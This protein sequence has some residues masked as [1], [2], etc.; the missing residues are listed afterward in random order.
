[1]EKHHSPHQGTHMEGHR[2]PDNSW[3]RWMGVIQIA[4]LLILV[5]QFGTLSGKLS[6]GTAGTGS[7]GGSG[8]QAAPPPQAPSAAQ[9]SAQLNPG[10][11]P[12]DPVLGDAG[13]AVSIVEFSDFQCPF[14]KRAFDQSL[15]DFKNSDYFKSGEV[16]LIYKHF[17]LDSIHPQATPAAV[18]AECAKAQGEFWAFHDTI[19]QNQGAMS[20]GS[21]KQWASDLGLDTGSFSACFDSSDTLAKVRADLSAAQAAGG[22]G[23]PY[24][25]VI[26]NKNGKTQP[27]SGAVPFSKLEEA[28]QAVR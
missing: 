10:I 4:L 13:A 21:Y 20:E 6:T 27:V 8:T 12:E 24:F 16:N 18:A 5:I 26:N 15:S 11:T 19:F 22:R 25:V 23:T 17:P 9:P 1:M 2:R 7:S 3:M 14:C 28:I